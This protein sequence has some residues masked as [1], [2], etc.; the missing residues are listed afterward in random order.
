[1]PDKR[2]HENHDDYEEPFDERGLLRDGKS[3]RVSLM[4]R[5]GMSPSQRAVAEDALARRF[6]LRHALDL[7]QCG[8]RHCTDAAANDAREKAYQEMCDELMNAWRTPSAPLPAPGAAARDATPARPV[9]DA[10]EGRRI[11]QAAWR[12]MVDEMTNA[13]RGPAR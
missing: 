10:A 5:D 1:M 11:K 6:G 4:M 12:E 3:V 2:P 8:P 9:Y 13:W 7:H